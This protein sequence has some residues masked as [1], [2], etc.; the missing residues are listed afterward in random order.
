MVLDISGACDFSNEQ[1]A[2]KMFAQI[3]KFVGANNAEDAEK[4]DQEEEDT[5]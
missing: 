2:E 3:K 4:K 5:E 1:L